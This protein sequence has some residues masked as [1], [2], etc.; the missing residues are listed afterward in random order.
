MKDINLLPDDIR[1]PQESVK[2]KKSATSP[3]KVIT[4]IV[5][6][7]ALVGVSLILP[8]VY[9]ITQN[10]R[11]DMINSSIESSKYDE[12]KAVNKQ[13]ADIT[14]KLEVKNNIILDI[15]KKYSSVSQL[16]KF[17]G[18]SAP[19]GCSYENIVFN[20][21]TLKIRG[22]VPDASKASEALSYMSR[23]DGLKVERTNITSKDN[24]VAFEFSFILT[25]KEGK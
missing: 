21:G 13:I 24:K 3:V 15:D 25:G 9:I 1:T 2:P 10:T 4:I 5:A 8:K 22:T 23:V 11:L 12:V 20:D 16:L 18:S 19:A 6:I 17:I 14:G 7:V